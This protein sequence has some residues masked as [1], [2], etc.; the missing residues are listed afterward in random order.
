[1]TLK[2]EGDL[3]ILKIYFNAENEVGIL[4]HSKLLELHEYVWLLQVK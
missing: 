1:M 4:R 3:D 2:F